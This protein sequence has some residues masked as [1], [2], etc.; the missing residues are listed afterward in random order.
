MKF[1][2][3]L[4]GLLV[5]VTAN[6][7]LA[8][9]RGMVGKRVGISD[10][11]EGWDVTEDDDWLIYHFTSSGTERNLSCGEQALLLIDPAG[12]TLCEEGQRLSAEGGLYFD[13]EA[14]EYYVV[15]E[16]VSCSD[17]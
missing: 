1:P 5:A 11:V 8:D 13:E 6:V 10:I 2:V 9:C 14:K 3:L 15:S 16:T 12:K 7:V 17:D 4:A